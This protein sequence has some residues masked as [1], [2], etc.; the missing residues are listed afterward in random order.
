M[1]SSKMSLKSKTNKQTKTKQNKNTSSKMSLK[2]KTK[3]KQ[4]TFFAFWHFLLRCYLRFNLVKIPWRSDNNWFQRYYQVKGFNNSETKK[5]STLFGEILKSIFV[6]S[7]SFCLITSQMTK[8]L[9]E[10]SHRSGLSHFAGKVASSFK[11]HPF[12]LD[13]RGHTHMMA[14]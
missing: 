3:T 10:I 12:I 14:V 4:N 9:C 11:I 13:R 7:N 8:I 1:Q 5:L 2:S 6:S